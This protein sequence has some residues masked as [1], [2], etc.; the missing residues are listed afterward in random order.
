GVS[1]TQTGLRGIPAFLMK[2]LLSVRSNRYEFEMD[3]LMITAKY[4]QPFVEEEI[5]TIY[6]ARNQAT[7]FNPILDSAR[8]Y[9][10]ILRFALSSAT[11]YLVELVLFAAMF[12]MSGSVLT[13]QV[14]S[15]VSSAFINYFLVR[16][17]VF[18]S[19]RK[20]LSPALSYALVVVFSGSLSYLAQIAILAEFAIHPIY[21]KILVETVIFFVNFAVLRSYVFTRR[22]DETQSD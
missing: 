7:H 6:F 12:A 9:F 21:V 10:S 18:H 8:I 2:E 22:I 5:K 16:D 15:R 19:T 20:R 14:F 11:S 1:D 3:M 4:Q 17:F 13:S